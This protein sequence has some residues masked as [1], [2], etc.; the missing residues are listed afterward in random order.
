MRFCLAL[1]ISSGLCFGQ[2]GTGSPAGQTSGAQPAR[3]NGTE[4]KQS[5]ATIS[6]QVLSVAG[7]PLNKVTVTFYRI[8][9]SEGGG[10]VGMPMPATNFTT[11]SEAGGKFTIQV[12]PGTY[13]MSADRPG[14]VR[15]GRGGRTGRVPP[16]LKLAAGQSETNVTLRMVPQGVITGKVLDQDGDPLSNV[17]VVAL[18]QRT[19][20]GQKRWMTVGQGQINDLGEYRLFGL[21][22]G[23]Y[24]LMANPMG[25][26]NMAASAAKR[27]TFAKTFYPNGLEMDQATALEVT[28]GGV[29]SNVDFRMTEYPVYQVKG[30]VTGASKGQNF[31]ISLVGMSGGQSNMINGPDAT[32]NVIDGAFSFSQVRPGTYY[33]QTMPMR[34]RGSLFG[35]T[36]ITVGEADLT[37]VV[38]NME[39]GAT[40]SGTVRIEATGNSNQSA[41]S[42]QAAGN[43]PPSLEHTQVY[44]LPDFSSPGGMNLGG[45]PPATIDATGNFK[46]ENVPPNRYTVSMNQRNGYV[47]SIR[48][49]NQPVVGNRID[50]TGGGGTIDVV[51]GT[52]SG[53]ITVI[54]QDSKQRLTPGASVIAAPDVNPPETDRIRVQQTDSEG[55]AKFV[56]LAPGDYKVYVVEDSADAELTDTTYLDRIAKPT[57]ITLKPGASESLTTQFTAPSTGSELEKENDE[58]EKQAGVK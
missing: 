37:D 36:T 28:A 21:A 1:L 42:S 22:P 27:K 32:T 49:G 38:V 50:V 54:A 41:S 57:K 16:P 40:V 7:E 9:G 58:R 13:S 20:Q 46:F 5:P 55:S 34:N 18:Q 19:M 30:R 3:S 25:R 17:F 26:F 6:G 52:D 10:A 12:P 11:T 45:T 48:F 8:P 47:K 53:T 24:Y 51:I 44:L 14:Y 23:R 2:S 29:L 31:G 39:P 43:T 15:S 35:H 56:N 4:P 33:L